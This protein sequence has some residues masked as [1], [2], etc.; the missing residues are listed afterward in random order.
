MNRFRHL[1]VIA[2]STASSSE[3]AEA[4]RGFLCA[5]LEIKCDPGLTRLL[6]G[7]R[8]NAHAEGLFDQFFAA[9]ETLVNSAHASGGLKPQITSS[10]I[11]VMLHGAMLA[12]RGLDGGA[13]T[14][15][16]YANVL[17]DGLRA[18]V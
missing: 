17:A 16:M 1:V 2:E 3:P 8:P 18:P 7:G 4:I 6:L 9:V 10:D 14:A 13:L 11:V 5:A 15:T 12:V